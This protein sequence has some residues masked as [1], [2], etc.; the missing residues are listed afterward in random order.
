MIRGALI[1]AVGFGLGYAKAIHEQEAH[2]EFFAG[3]KD[4]IDQLRENAAKDAEPELPADPESP[5]P[6]P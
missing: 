1:L 4:F 6:Q 5:T 3:A 2:A